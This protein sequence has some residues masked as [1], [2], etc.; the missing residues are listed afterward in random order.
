MQKKTLLAT[1]LLGALVCATPTLAQTN[2]APAA[3][4]KGAVTMPKAAPVANNKARMTTG[5]STTGKA[6]TGDVKDSQHLVNRAFAEVQTMEKDPQLKKLMAKAKGVFLVPD[7]GRGAFII[8]GRGGAGLVLSHQNGKWSNPAFYDIGGVSLGAQ[9]G[10][11][12][13]PIAFLLMDQSAVDAFKSGNKFSL[14]AGAGLSIVTYSANK[15]AC[16]ARA[17][18]SCG[19]TPRAL[20]SAPLSACRT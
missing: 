13:G 6:S 18:S 5:T 10:G 2:T 4:N 3:N 11:P 17:T 15:Q 8:G 1:T 9:V 7:F 20:M 12:G 19:R 14:N 16:G